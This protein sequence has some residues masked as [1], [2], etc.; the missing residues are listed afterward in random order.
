MAEPYRHIVICLDFS[1]HSDRAFEKARGL[2]TREGADLTILHVVVPGLPLVPGEEPPKKPSRI[3]DEEIVGKLQRH[4]EENY[5]ARC[6]GPA[7]QIMLRRGYPSVE[8]LD[9]LRETG[10]DLVVMGSAGLSGMGL[11]LLGSV[12]ERV[13][14]KAPC[15]C[16]IVR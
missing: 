9:H 5:L 1:E 8:I 3:P 15:D 10:A 4:I 7:C 13:C 14:R 2:A 12:A 6:G 11:V 16:L